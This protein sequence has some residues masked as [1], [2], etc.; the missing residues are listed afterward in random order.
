MF[1]LG[2]PPP[3]YFWIIDLL[4]LY[5]LVLVTGMLREGF[6]LGYGNRVG[7]LAMEIFSSISLKPLLRALVLMVMEI[8]YSE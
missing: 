1:Q 4:Q 6:I 8:P 7:A 3:S 5:I 2:S